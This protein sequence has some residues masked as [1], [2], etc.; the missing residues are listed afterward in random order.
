[1]ALHG[2]LDCDFTMA[3]GGGAGNSQQA[4]PL[5]SESSSSI[6]LHHAQAAPLLFLPNLS[7]TYLHIMV[8]LI[9]G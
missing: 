1:M 7:T 2:G 9:V 8:V 6:F 4:T 5:R 3:L